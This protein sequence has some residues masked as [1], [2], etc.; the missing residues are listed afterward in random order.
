MDRPLDGIPYDRPVENRDNVS[1]AEAA[2]YQEHALRGGQ[3]RAR[4]EF[5]VRNKRC[6]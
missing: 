3:A 4:I 5:S 2:I 6:G 1:E